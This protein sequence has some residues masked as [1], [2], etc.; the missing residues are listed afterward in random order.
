VHNRGIL[1][2]GA[3]ILAALY[4][5]LDEIEMFTVT[6][7]LDALPNALRRRIEVLSDGML[8]TVT[9]ISKSNDLPGSS[10]L[11]DKEFGGIVINRLRDA[12]GLRETWSRS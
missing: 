7:T 8:V 3:L 12:F 6:F 4:I 5:L 10:A 11:S 1:I 2:S 9:R